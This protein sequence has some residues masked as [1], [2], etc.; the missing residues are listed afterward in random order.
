MKKIHLFILALL[1]ICN[2][3]QAIKAQC[4]PPTSLV[5]RDEFFSNPA[6]GIHISIKKDRLDRP[7]IYV[8]SKNAGLKIFDISSVNNPTLVATIS[9]TLFGNLDA[10]QVV[11]EGQ[12]LYLT[13]GDIW[14]TN[15]EAG[16]AIIDVKNPLQA[17]V[18]DYYVHPGSSGGAGSVFI[19]NGLA[20][21]AAM[22]NGLIILDIQDKNKIVFKSQVKLS[23]SFPHKDSS[24]VAAYNA[25]G[26]WVRDSIA[27]ICYDR[28]GLRLVDVSN[29]LKIQQIAQYCFAPLIDKA[30]AYN[31]ICIYEH[32]AFVSLDYYGMEVLDISN[33]K[34]LKQVSWWH[35]MTWA[36]TSTNFQTWANSKGHANELIYDS[37]CHKIIMACGRTDLVVLDVA[38]PKQPTT[39]A[40][41][42]SDSDDYGTWGIDFYKQNAYVSYIWSPFFPPYSN[43]TGFRIVD[44]KDC[45][46]TRTMQF[47]KGSLIQQFQDPVADGSIQLNLKDVFKQVQLSI[48]TIEGLKLLEQSFQNRQQ[49][50]ISF[51][52]KQG[53][54]WLIVQTG[55]QQ[56]V[57]K[58]FHP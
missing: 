55:N 3:Q 54:Y 7:F 1:C 43:Y 58:F 24:N 20:Y 33:P 38:D 49:L 25:R 8:T 19:Q 16:L 21:L 29:P 31:A 39:C 30:T 27:Y 15:Q 46:T 12:L 42:G 56:E 32:Y 36:D 57:L 34:N 37:S 2:I 51:Q 23:N 26:I 5:Q 44:V 47:L 14:N 28:G 50:N 22:R 41:F 4:N 18:T 48:Y 17:K 40:L 52:A 35:P 9:P 13:L 11:Q 6:F 45:Q 53:I 10:I